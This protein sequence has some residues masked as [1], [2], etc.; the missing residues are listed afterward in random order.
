MYSLQKNNLTNDEMK[1]SNMQYKIAEQDRLLNMFMLVEKILILE[2]EI[3]KL[4][5]SK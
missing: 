2:E 1:F 5:E 4:K 3:C